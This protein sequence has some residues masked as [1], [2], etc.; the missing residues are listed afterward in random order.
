MTK[1]FIYNPNA[2]GGTEYMG[3]G[4]HKTIASHMP[5]LEN[6]D[7]Y[8]IPGM[9]PNMEDIVK[10]NKQLII[11]MHNTPQQFDEYHLQILKN[12]KFLEKVKYFI[13]P[14]KHHKLLTLEE[15]DIN[16]DNIYVIPNALEP[17][18]FNKSKFDNPLEIKLIHTSSLDRGLEILL[19]A[20][21]HIK[22]D[23]RVEI[24]NEF[25]PDLQQEPPVFD[26]RIK[27]YGKTPKATVIEAIEN[28]HIH[29]YPSMYPET[30]CMSQVE[31]MSAGLICVTSD[32][33][34]L[35]EVSGGFGYM[36]PYEKDKSKHTELFVNNL[37][38]AISDIRKN[39]FD[40]TAQIEYVNNTYSWEAIKQ[41]WIEFHELI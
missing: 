35:P 8:I 21:P 27:F 24:Y 11:W 25:Y 38:K 33:G 40:P 36:Y 3:R 1:P 6:Y 34:A 15:L 18:N 13:V 2:F 29:A 14:S 26:P 5:K 37:N 12:P 22:E 16:P 20:I 19:Y 30:F 9:T 32:L 23:I 28:S 41:K 4:W 17:L 10:S 31:A 7:A 39:N